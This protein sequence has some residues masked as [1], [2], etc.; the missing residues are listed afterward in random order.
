MVFTLLLTQAPPGWILVGR[1]FVVNV[2]DTGMCPTPG[3]RSA[4]FATALAI[5]L[6]FEDAQARGENP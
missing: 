5:W 4:L 6:A 3:S 2:P 1:R